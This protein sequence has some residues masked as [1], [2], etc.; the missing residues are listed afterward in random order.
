M[1]LP[2]TTFERRP[3]AAAIGAALL[4][5]ALPVAAQQGG[6][7]G[8][9][10]PPTDA[11]PSR[12]VDPLLA[13]AK[14]AK[15]YDLG[16]LFQEALANDSTYQA[17]RFQYQVTT[18]QPSIARAGLL[19]SLDANASVSR[20]Y[21]DL[22]TSSNSVTPNFGDYG[23]GLQLSVPVYRPQQWQTFEQAK[24]Q[25][26]QGEATL[27][28]A[29]QDLIL[30][31]ARAYFDALA[32]RDQVIAL[33]AN[34]TATLQQLEQAKREFEVGTKTIIDTNEAQARYD[35]IVAQLQV[36]VGTLLVRRSEL[37]AIVGRDIG[38]LAGLRDKPGLA[39]PQPN[40]LPPW[41]KATED[42]NY[43]VLANRVSVEIAEREI[44]KARDG[45]KPTLDV[46]GSANRTRFDGSQSTDTRFRADSANIGLQLNWPI[47]SGGLTQA[48]V[49]AALSSRDKAGA[50]LETARRTAANAAR[51]AFTGVNYGL[52][53]VRSLESAE[54][55]ARTQL[56][57][58]QLGY[59]V[60]VRILLDV[61]NA[62]TQLITTQ[63]DLKQARYNFLVFGLQLKAAAG[64][65]SDDDVRTVNALL[66][67]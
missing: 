33:E 21:Y 67:E 13:E 17:A 58:T 35:Q 36:A 10:P 50:D 52:S 40:E 53:Q 32:A 25:V 65:L 5:L 4:A 45:Y 54:T 19:P 22:S 9:L 51:S 28:Q 44:Q 16:Q 11:S 55:S 27:A 18:E 30:R 8:Q 6:G 66:T 41:L 47:Y 62:Q 64:T 43:G 1:H 29:R 3:L 7:L 34:K 20:R 37:E 57:S 31:L 24:L 48:Q 59:Q 60:G 56:E 14:M 46:V 61:L 15:R 49:R 23:G 2:Q 38:T 26:E 12:V 39:L 63:R 42:G